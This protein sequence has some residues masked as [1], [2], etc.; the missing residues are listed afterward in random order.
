MGGNMKQKISLAA[1]SNSTTFEEGYLEFIRMRKI[2]NVSSN[3]IKHYNSTFKRFTQFFD[4]NTLCSKIDKNTILD[5]VE[6][7][8]EQNP[9]IKAKSVNSYLIDL[10]AIFNYLMEEDAIPKF[11][12]KLLREE[13]EII[14]TYNNSELER[15]LKKPDLK[16]CN[17][18]EYRNWVICNYL[19][20]TGVRVGTLC[21]TR[22]CDIDFNTNQIALKKVKN[23]R[24]YIIPLSPKLAK[25]LREYLQY[26]KAEN[27]DD[28]LF[29]N[30]YGEPLNYEALHTAIRRYNQ[31]RGVEQTGIHLFRHTFAKLW[32]VNGGDLGT[33]QQILGHSTM[34]M[35]LHYA[36]L[37]GQNYTNVFLKFNPLEQLENSKERKHINMEK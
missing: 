19:M 36:K 31:S 15:L 14:K 9:G 11:T 4:K 25:I 37:F 26:R 8:E 27:S 17:F 5:F 1:T 22:I 30:T 21:A 12:V 32:I 13:D 2:M 34:Q 16:K 18:S 10:R 7:L 6:W 24:Q 23:K 20:A 3:T 28:A 35:T 33:L 29:C